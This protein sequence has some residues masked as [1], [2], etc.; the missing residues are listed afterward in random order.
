MNRSKYLALKLSLT[1]KATNNS[2]SY[3]TYA[4]QKSQMRQSN[5]HAGGYD[6]AKLAAEGGY[7]ASDYA[8]LPVSMEIKDL[9]KTIQRYTP[10]MQDIDTK[11]KAFVPDFIPAIGEVDAFLK[12][13]RPDGKPQIL[14]LQVVV[15]I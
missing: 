15:Q 4:G 9:F 13:P 8:H 3:S 11:M 7:Q 10:V 14:G 12:M 5:L 1:L 6:D 2:V